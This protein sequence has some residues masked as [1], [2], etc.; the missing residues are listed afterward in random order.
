MLTPMLF[1]ILAVIASI[2]AYLQDPVQKPFDALRFLVGRWAGEGT[3]TPGTSDPNLM[4]L[5]FEIANP[6]QANVF[7]SYI[8]ATLHRIR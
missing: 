7:T 1:T 3:G 6:N 2:P 8:D 4:K 5:K